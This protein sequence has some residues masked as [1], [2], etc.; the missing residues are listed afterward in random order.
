[1]NIAILG[2]GGRE[3][4]I[5]DKLKQSKSRIIH[6]EGEPEFDANDLRS[7]PAM[8]PGKRPACDNLA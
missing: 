3:H 4:S 5:C 2:S 1:M 6:D 8:P 7:K